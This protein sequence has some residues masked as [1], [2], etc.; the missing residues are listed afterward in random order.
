MGVLPASR[1]LPAASGGKTPTF[2]R[3]STPTSMSC[4]TCSATLVGERL[5]PPAREKIG[6]ET[7]RVRCEELGSAN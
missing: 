4:R 6:L 5:E 7:C 1:R 3:R 2:Y